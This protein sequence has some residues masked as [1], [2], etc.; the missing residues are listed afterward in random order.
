MIPQMLMVVFW[1]GIG[2]FLV[3]GGFW[4]CQKATLPRVVW[5]V[6]AVLVLVVIVLVISGQIPAPMGV[7]AFHSR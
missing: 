1:L 5:I 3:W 6:W 4:V 7:P 2:S